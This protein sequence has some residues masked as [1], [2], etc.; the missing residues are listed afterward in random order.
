MRLIVAACLLV[1]GICAAGCAQMLQ[2][3]GNDRSWSGRHNASVKAPEESARVPAVSNADDDLARVPCASATH[4]LG[5]H[6]GYTHGVAVRLRLCSVPGFPSSSTE[7][8]PGSHYYVPGASGNVIVSSEVSTAVTGLLRAARRNGLAL[9]ASSSFRSRQHQADLCSADR[10]CRR[11]DYKYV[12]PPG[13]SAHQSGSA[14]DFVGPVTKGSQSCGYGRA[15]DP[16]SRVW[17]FLYRNA[18][19]FGFRQ[20]AAESWHWDASGDPDRC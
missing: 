5:V 14:I 2:G 17:R 4:D 18:S 10:L 15:V 6:R 7:S 9:A 20:Y 11:G 1:L 12:A 8:R 16:G 13:Y 3:P 19:D